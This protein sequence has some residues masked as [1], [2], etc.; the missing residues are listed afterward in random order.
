VR[1]LPGKP[2]LAFIGLKVAVFCDGAFWHGHPDHFTFG[3]SGAYWDKKI[4]RTK[5]RD[6][7]ANLAL[8]E[9]GWKVIRFW[10]FEIADDLDRCVL[11][12]SQT[13]AARREEAML[14]PS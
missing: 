3:K 5:E 7:E 1:S 8:E 12:V 13:V 2:D 14:P 4:A 10:D 6:Q 11:D 9:L